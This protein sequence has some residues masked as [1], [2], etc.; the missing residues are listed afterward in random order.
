MFFPTLIN[1]TLALLW[2]AMYLG[3]GPAYMLFASGIAAGVAVMCLV[4]DV[5][6]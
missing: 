6:K 4:I 2:G 1:G 3:G 5:W